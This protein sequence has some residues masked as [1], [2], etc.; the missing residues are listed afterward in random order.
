MSTTITTDEGF[1]YEPFVTGYRIGYRVTFPS[2]RVETVSVVPSVATDEG[3]GHGNVF[4][5]ASGDAITDDPGDAFTHIAFE[6][7]EAAA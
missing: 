2:G 6:D 3:P 7:E 5:Y 4:F 1:T